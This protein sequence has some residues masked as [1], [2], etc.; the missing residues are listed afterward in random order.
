MTESA[1][2]FRMSKVSGKRKKIRDRDTTVYH[3]NAIT[4]RDLDCRDRVHYCFSI[5]T[6]ADIA[7][8][9]RAALMLA[10]HKRR[11]G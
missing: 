2:P 8:Q 1:Q 5:H 11:V 3:R 6:A 10:Y 4:V 9:L 7:D